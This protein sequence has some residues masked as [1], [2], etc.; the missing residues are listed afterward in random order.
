M[1]ESSAS[2]IRSRVDAKL[3]ELRFRTL[4]TDGEPELEVALD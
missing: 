1:P 3:L 2:P 4:L